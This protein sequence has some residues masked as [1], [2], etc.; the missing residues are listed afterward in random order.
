MKFRLGAMA[1]ACNPSTL[2]GPGG[3]ITGSQEFE[4]SLANIHF[5]RPKDHLTPGVQDQ[6]GQHNETIYK[7]Q[8]LARRSG[9]HL[10]SLATWEAEVLPLLDSW[11]HSSGLPGALGPSATDCRLPSFEVLGFGLAFLLLSL[12][13]A[14][15]GTSPWDH[16]LALLPR[17]E[18]SGMISTYG[19]LR[20]P[21]SS[22]SPLSLLS[23]E[24][25]LT[26]VI[27]ALWE[28][29]VG[30]SPEVRS[31]E[32]TLTNTTESPSVTRLRCSDAISAHC[33][34]CLPGSSDSPAS[35]SQ[36]A[37]TTGTQHHIQ[38][39]F[40]WGF[41]MLVSLVLNS[42]PQA[43]CP[44]QPPKRQEPRYVTQA[45]LELLGSEMGFHH[46]T[47]AGLKLL[48]SSDPPT[49]ASHLGLQHFERLRQTDHLRSGV[50]DQPGQH[51]E[52]C[53]Y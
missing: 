20:L 31:S 22:N 6:P 8:N 47:Q 32:M 29:K 33:N 48:T 16:S 23:Q 2:G 12:Q 7:M 37:R 17:L 26:P 43:I 9:T 28:T 46:V 18:C 44:P 21:G 45:G 34:L 25:W 41:S 51:R 24:Q 11:T 36:V 10:L 27:S 50:R 1:H 38:L 39:I 52:I 13:T 19:N 14:Y 4:T 35:V 53:L 30:R 15:C 3:R 42:Q 49:L 5:G 40:T